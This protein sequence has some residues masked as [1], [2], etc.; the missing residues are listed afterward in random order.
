M[1]EESKNINSENVISI[2][3]KRHNIM[4][5]VGNGFDM[6]ALSWLNRQQ[7][8]SAKDAGFGPKVLSSYSNFVDYLLLTKKIDEKK[9]VVFKKIYSRYIEKIKDTENKTDKNWCNFEE[10]VHNLV[11]NETDKNDVKRIKK[12]EEDLL[13]LQREFS[14][15][16]NNLLPAEKIVEYDKLVSKGRFAYHSFQ[17]FLSDMQFE[18]KKHIQ[19]LCFC[20]TIRHDHELNFLFVD[21]N[22]TMLL[23][24]YVQLD[25][26]QFLVKP[27]KST[28]N[29]F[30]F[31]PNPN[32]VFK[33]FKVYDKSG[34]QVKYLNEKTNPQPVN[35]GKYVYS[36][37]I[38]TQ[39]VHPHGIQDVPRSIL[40]GTEERTNP[41][42]DRW[43]FVKH[44]WA[45][46]KEKYKKN[47]EETELFII[48]G[49]SISKTDGWWM[50]EIYKELLKNESKNENERT[51]ELII[52]DNITFSERKREDIISDFFNAC[53]S[54]HYL[55]NDEMEQK[56]KIEK[57]IYVINYVNNKNYFLGDPQNAEKKII[58]YNKNID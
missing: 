43:R 45:Q 42:D 55:T 12:I 4:C 13:E 25:R 57:Y 22:Y 49:L 37:K 58:Y 38:I 21:F 17:N 11:F 6:A 14:I 56:G 44:L 40:F 5:L 51:R 53:E 26:Y 31:R 52:Y 39:V 47:L 32:K 50:S 24:S 29:N 33:R 48:F 30:W 9:N 1:S 20:K 8:S 19:D 36:T 35:T 15:F 41:G 3:S 7:E 23:D 2:D 27:H 18:E 16:L 10:I 28:D 54:C 34:K 46:D